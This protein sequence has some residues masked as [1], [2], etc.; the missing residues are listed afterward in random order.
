MRGAVA[1]KCPATFSS[2]LLVV[3][4]L[5]RDVAGRF[6][7]A[8]DAFLD[9][10]KRDERG[11]NGP[12]RDILQHIRGNGAAQT[13]EIINQLTASRREKQPVGT[14]VLRVIPPF[15]KAV[16]DQTIEQAHQ[17]DRLQFQHVGQIDLRQSLLL[18]QSKQYNPL[19]ARGATALGA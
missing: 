11:F 2:S 19:R 14:T 17:R 16:L 5:G 12:G 6:G 8:L 10:S 18:P 13:V 9:V 3:R 4:L 1:E 7:K 15:K